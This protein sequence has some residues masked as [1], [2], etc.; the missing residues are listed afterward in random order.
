MTLTFKYGLLVTLGIALWIL[1]KHFLLQ[2]DDPQSKAAYLDLLFFNLLPIIM[3]YRGIKAKRAGHNGE[4]TFLEGFKTGLMISL[5]YTI[6]I[7][8][9]FLVLYVITGPKVLGLDSPAQSVAA[10]QIL[11]QH[12]AGLFIFMIIGG[13]LY[14]TIISLT[15][16]KRRKASNDHPGSSHV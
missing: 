11:F 7:C 2:I 9:F 1:I 12:F 10:G 16:R 15:L 6:L 8:L 14:S 3:L 5:V 13:L 4:L